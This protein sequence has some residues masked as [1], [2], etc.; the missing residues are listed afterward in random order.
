MQGVTLRNRADKLKRELQQ[1]RELATLPEAADYH[2][3]MVHRRGCSVREIFRAILLDPPLAATILREACL[4]R[5]AS[6]AK[7]ASLDDAIRML[8]EQSIRELC[9]HQPK[10]ST[11][12]PWNELN[13]R[14]ETLWRHAVGTGILAK[15]LH[16]RKRMNRIPGPDPYLAG[17]LHHIGWFVLDALKPALVREAIRRFHQSGCWSIEDE[18]ALF[19][20]DHAE[21]GALLLESWG[22]PRDLVSVIRHHHQASLANG[23]SSHAAL[24]RIASVLSP[25]PFPL[26]TPLDQIESTLPNRLRFREGPRLIE[27]MKDRYERYIHQAENGSR[28]ML[29][30]L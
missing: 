21:I 8:P 16:L 22:L 27:E 1:I 13:V 28:L 12:A 18:R 24:L 30:W 23:L 7:P 10:L 5:P 14:T 19:G 11:F 20:L 26:E 17:L 25:D 6:T 9:L 15:A 3:A 4:H 29:S 2:Q